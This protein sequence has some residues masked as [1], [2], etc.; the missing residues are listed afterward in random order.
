MQTSGLLH[1]VITPYNEQASSNSSVETRSKHR[2][3]NFMPGTKSRRSSAAGALGE[4]WRA[5]RS[6]K[7]P[8]LPGEGHLRL[9]VTPLQAR[10]HRGYSVEN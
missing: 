9:Q 2:R 5:V 3:D 10:F 4:A 7:H 6:D 1:L 8:C